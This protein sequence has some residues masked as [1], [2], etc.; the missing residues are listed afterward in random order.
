[1]IGGGNENNM[2]SGTAMRLSEEPP[3]APTDRRLLSN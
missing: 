3:V 1:M 2:M